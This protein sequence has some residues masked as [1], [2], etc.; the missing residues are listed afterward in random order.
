VSIRDS[1]GGKSGSYGSSTGFWE[2]VIEEFRGFFPTLDAL[3]HY[4]VDQNRGEWFGSLLCDA[5]ARIGSRSLFGV[6]ID[7]DRKESS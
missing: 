4:R 5:P 3:R 2:S 6:I 7:E 1:H